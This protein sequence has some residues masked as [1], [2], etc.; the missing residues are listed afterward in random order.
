MNFR[1]RA[2]YF[3]Y[4]MPL[5]TTEIISNIDFPGDDQAASAKEFTEV[6]KEMIDYGYGRKQGFVI[7]ISSDYSS[8]RKYD[9]KKGMTLKQK[10]EQIMRT[11]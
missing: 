3:I 8:I 4:N 7:E 6:V 11:I 2:Y 5:G 10:A 1:D 9:M